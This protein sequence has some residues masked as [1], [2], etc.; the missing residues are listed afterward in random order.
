MEEFIKTLT[1]QMRCARARD[2][3][4]R[5]LSDHI[6]DQ[7]EAYEQSGMERGKAVAKAVRE[8]GDPV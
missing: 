3:V 2:G 5:E 8:M 1:E 4:A 7:A 6:L